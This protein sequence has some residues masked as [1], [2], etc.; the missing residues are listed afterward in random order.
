MKTKSFN[1][2]VLKEARKNN[3][4]ISA[5]E[6]FDEATTLYK[7]ERLEGI[8]NREI[9]RARIHIGRVNHWND[10]NNVR[11]HAITEK[12]ALMSAYPEK[13]S[14]KSELQILLAL[15]EFME[16]E[17]AYY[18]TGDSYANAV[19]KARDNGKRFVITKKALNPMS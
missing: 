1:F 11:V 18:Y 6:G 15:I 2:E 7:K 10:G 16:N 13:T 5:I 8:E 4:S 17:S 14:F 9:E 12:D 3:I 19:R